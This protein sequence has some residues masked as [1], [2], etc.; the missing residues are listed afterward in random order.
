M[1]LLRDYWWAIAIAAVVV[2][3]AL[4]LLLRPRQ[5]VTLTDSAPMRPHMQQPARRTE[6]LES[7]AVAV[8]APRPGAAVGSDD[9]SKLKGVGPKFA[10]ALQDAGLTRFQQIASLSP[11]D[12]DALDDRLGTFC[13]RLKR[14]RV[15]EQADYLARDDISGFEAK[16][17]K[18]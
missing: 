8:P 1:E 4:F 6:T 11:A 3:I 14:D 7:A 12:V 15:V 13:G 5:R 17:G 9:L 2:L 18:L 10:E 16:F